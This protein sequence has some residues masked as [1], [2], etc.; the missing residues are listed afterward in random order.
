M[1]Y[2]PIY[3]FEDSNAITIHEIHLVNVAVAVISNDNESMMMMIMMSP[4]NL[5]FLKYLLN[6]I[7]KYSLKPMHQ[8][9]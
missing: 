4:F 8:S 9:G 2:F 3:W 7:L 1:I 6:G 5:Q